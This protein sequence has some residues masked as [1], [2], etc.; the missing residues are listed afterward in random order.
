MQEGKLIHPT[1]DW[2]HTARNNISLLKAA[3]D[4]NQTKLTSFYDIVDKVSNIV[5]ESPQLQQVLGI[6]QDTHK[7][8]YDNTKVNPTEKFRN[9]YYLMQSKMQIKL[10]KEDDMI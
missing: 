2:S 9:S 1:T 5:Q 3:S 8:A 4:P 6:V 10:Q 7:E